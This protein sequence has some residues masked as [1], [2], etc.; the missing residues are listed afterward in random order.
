MR[1]PVRQYRPQCGTSTHVVG[2]IGHSGPGVQA[3]ACSLARATWG[4]RACDRYHLV[5]IDLGL[6][7]MSGFAVCTAYQQCATLRSTAQFSLAH[8]AL[9]FASRALVCSRPRRYCAEQ[10]KAPALTLALTADLTAEIDDSPVTD[11]GFARRLTKPLSSSTILEM[12]RTWLAAPGTRS[13]DGAAS[14]LGS[15]SLR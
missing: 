1:P 10:G 8:R 11:F 5:I 12:L 2:A 13:I 6:P 9:S 3:S 4:P 7:D 14:S 15:L